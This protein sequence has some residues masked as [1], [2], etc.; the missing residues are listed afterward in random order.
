MK[1]VRCLIRNIHDWFCLISS[2]WM[3]GRSPF[4]STIQMIGS[5]NIWLIDNYQY[6][7]NVWFINQKSNLS[8]RQLANTD[9]FPINCSSPSPLPQFKYNICI[10]WS[11]FWS[12][13]PLYLCCSFNLIFTLLQPISQ[14]LDCHFY[15]IKPRVFKFY[16]HS[17]DLCLKTQCQCD[18]FSWS[19]YPEQPKPFYNQAS[20]VSLKD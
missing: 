17:S 5:L 11:D 1:S 9:S 19:K 20:C 10:T 14:L 15:K 18:H 4:K 6:P 16:S 8:R 7:F 13:L 2:W 3:T 12:C